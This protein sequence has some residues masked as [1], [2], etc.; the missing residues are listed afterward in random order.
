MRRE[1]LTIS[2][3]TE[4]RNSTAGGE[5]GLEQ[6]SGFRREN[7]RSDVHGVIELGVG[8]DLK[9]GTEGAAL[10]VVGSVDE[11]RNAGLDDG[12][13]THGAR[14]ESDVKSGA[15]EAVIA[16]KASAFPDHDNFGVGGGVIVTDGAVPGTSE[17]GSFMNEK[18]SD[19]DFASFGG[20]AGLGKCE[21]HE[22]Q[23]VRH[24]RRGE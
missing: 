22:L 19:G 21:L 24:K 13:G 10:G 3:E 20:G 4:G 7:A 6:G 9:A 16:E 14:L 2:G 17:N 8:E 18:S 23:I 12:A 5:E 1:T 15:A 11:A